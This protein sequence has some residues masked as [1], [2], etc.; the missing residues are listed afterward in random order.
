MSGPFGVQM[1]KVGE[2][3]IPGPEL[4]WLS[5][6]DEWF[7]L[8]F[9]IALIRGPGVCALVNTGPAEDLAQMNDHWATVLGD[10]ARM[11]REEGWRVMTQLASAGVAP[12]DVTHII[13]TPLQLYSTSNVDRFPNAEI[14]L[15]KQGWVHF[16]TTHAHV[17]DSR[18]HCIPRHVLTYMVTDAWDR[19]R[20]LEDEDEVVPGLRTWWAGSHHRATLAVEVDSTAGT[21]VITDAFF[22]Y[23]NLEEDHP[24]G[25]CEN[26]YEAMEAHRRT[27]AVADHAIP[28]YDPLVFER[29]PG[30]VVAPLPA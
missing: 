28:L 6:W 10:R 15:S 9:Q 26:I 23:R 20:L 7:R 13:L 19:V 8:D 14:C 30:G 22:H 2:G 24:I 18:W 4:L 21:V 29:H 17:H 16:H 5:G 25:V 3:D 12:E 1:L 11:R 27:R